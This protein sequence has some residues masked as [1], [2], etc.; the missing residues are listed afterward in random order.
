MG[1]KPIENLDNRKDKIIKC[2]VTKNDK[3]Y[4][5]EFC[6]ENKV[7]VRELIIRGMADYIYEQRSKS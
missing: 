3:N 2:R 1:R 5:L 6:K 7:S 4:I